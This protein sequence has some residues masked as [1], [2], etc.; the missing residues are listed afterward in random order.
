MSK[1]THLVEET[2]K[3]IKM[4]WFGSIIMFIIGLFLLT[5]NV[6]LGIGVMVGSVIWLIATK[7]TRWWKHA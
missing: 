6:S 5:A 4:S 7:I 1:K 2:S 3:G